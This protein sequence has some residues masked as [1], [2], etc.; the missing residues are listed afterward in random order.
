VTICLLQESRKLKDIDM[1]TVDKYES[2][3]V[4]IQRMTK[5][6]LFTVC[7]GRGIEVRN[8]EDAMRAEL[9]RKTIASYDEQ[10][11]ELIGRRQAEAFKEVFEKPTT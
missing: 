2:A 8:N 11:R 1:A 7:A 10:D 3:I 6:E 4:G 5:Q 9:I